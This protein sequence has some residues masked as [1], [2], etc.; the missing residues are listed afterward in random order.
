MRSLSN[1]IAVAALLATNT[2]VLAKNEPTMLES[3]K[4]MTF[5]KDMKAG[6][7]ELDIDIRENPEGYMSE[8]AQY[9][10]NLEEQKAEE[11]LE[12]E[13]DWDDDGEEL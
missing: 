9:L 3:L 12:L 5:G 2:K 13:T 4:E 7:I 8:A 1:I 6:I 10:M 11:N